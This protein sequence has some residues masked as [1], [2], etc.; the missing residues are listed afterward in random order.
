PMKCEVARQDLSA[1]MDGTPVPART[2][3]HL[4]TCQ[5]CRGFVRQLEELRA[6]SVALGSEPL[7]APDVVDRVL[8][9]LPVRSPAV[10]RW[11]VA[12][13]FALGAVIGAVVAGG[14]GGPR[15]SFAIELPE[16]VVAAQ[17]AVHRLTA[18]FTVTESITPDARRT[19]LGELSYRSPE[20]LTI[21]VTQTAGPVGWPVNSWSLAVDGETAVLS[22]PFPCPTLGGCPEGGPRTRVTTGRDPFSVIVPAPLDVV[23]PS[24]ILRNGIE[25]ERFDS[26]ELLGRPTVAF[27]VSA[28]QARSLLDGYFKAGNWREIHPTDLVAIWLDRDSFI[29]LQVAVTP[30]G[31]ADRMLWAARRGYLDEPGTPYLVVEYVEVDLTSEVVAMDPV[32]G[33]VVVDAG[34]RTDMDLVP[35]VDPGLPLVAAGTVSGR[36]ATT[37]WAWSDGRAWIRLDLTEEWAGPGLFGNDGSAVRPFE[38]SVGPIFGSGGGDK[39]YVHGAG[40]DALISG[41]LESATLE[42]LANDLPGVKLFLPADWP[43]APAD[44]GA[45]ERAWLPDGMTEY[46]EP[47]VR[48]SGEIFEADLFAAGGRSVHI[49]S[50][51]ATTLAPPL[52][53]DARAV[54]VR[55]TIG[56]YSPMLGLLEWTEG[57]T[58]VSI[59]SATASLDELLA[60]A[61]SLITPPSETGS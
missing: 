4:E 29:P 3:G 17:A 58:S 33:G 35:P 10:R 45:V 50:R 57:D 27:I 54:E 39:V 28:A 16:A 19:Y 2:I 40:F 44:P 1:S 30:G 43:E 59:G 32:E 41:S 7:V 26:A 60:I 49:V 61:L 31:S 20:L 18:S 48:A 6:R 42:D 52:D 8:A 5:D 47:I 14:I 38:T 9:R 11:S 21:E 53:P 55:G 13:G 34:F 46:S 12:T 56:R 25:P 22:T 51:P 36:V 15:T 24:S 23:V 37:V